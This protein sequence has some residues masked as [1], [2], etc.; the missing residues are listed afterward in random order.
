MNKTI[1]NSFNLNSFISCLVTLQLDTARP[2]V[3]NKPLFT[4]QHQDGSVD[5]VEEVFGVL[6]NTVT[7]GKQVS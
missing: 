5:Q 7:V 4:F 3:A 1:L 2:L 6:L